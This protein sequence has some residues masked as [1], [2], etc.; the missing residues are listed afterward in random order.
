MVALQKIFN[1]RQVAF[2][3]LLL[4]IVFS[5]SG[6]SQEMTADHSKSERKCAQHAVYAVAKILGHGVDWPL[7]DEEF[8]GEGDVSFA[9][10]RDNGVSR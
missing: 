1:T 9:S 3:V 5:F 6:M 2:L 10:I 8:G 4:G 7:I